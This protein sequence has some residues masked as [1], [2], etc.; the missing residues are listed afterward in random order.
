M[1]TEG[2]WDAVQMREVAQQADVALGTLYRYFPSKEYLLVSMMIAEIEVLADRLAVKPPQGAEPVDRVIDVLRR[3]NRALQRRP[4][5]TIATIRA[6]VSGNTEIAPAVKETTELM[7][8][9]ISD[10]LMVDHAHPDDAEIRAA[11]LDAADLDAAE[12]ELARADRAR[13]NSNQTIVESGESEAVQ[14]TD[15]VDARYLVPIELLRDIGLAALIAWIT[16]VE[17]D[18]SVRPQ[19]EQATRVLFA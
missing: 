4:L 12:L 11:G 3:A 2:G 7:R 14:P 6:L 18:E 10:A 5:A 9:I 17:S 1:A 8:R 13:R 15:L 16:G 19:L